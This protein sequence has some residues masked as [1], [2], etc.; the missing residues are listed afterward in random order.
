MTLKMMT[1]IDNDDND[2]GVDDVANDWA[3]GGDIN[4][5]DDFDVDANEDYVVSC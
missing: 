4:E 3:A 1:M 5:D 2:D